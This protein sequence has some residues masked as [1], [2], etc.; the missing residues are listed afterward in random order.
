LEIQ[1]GHY[2]SISEV[3]VRTAALKA[4]AKRAAGSYLALDTLK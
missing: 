1:R 3:S 2:Q 4:Q